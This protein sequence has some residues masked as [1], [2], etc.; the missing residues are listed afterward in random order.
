[1]IGGLATR[2]KVVLIEWGPKDPADRQGSGGRGL[3]NYERYLPRGPGSGPQAGDG[4]SSVSGCGGSWARF[5]RLRSIFLP[6]P[7]QK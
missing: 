3:G 1:V 7:L 4:P 2:E 5:R 6:C